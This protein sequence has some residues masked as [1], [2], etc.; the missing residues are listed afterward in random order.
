VFTQQVRGRITTQAEA[1]RIP[2][3]GS[4]RQGLYDHFLL[5]LGTYRSL[6]G[7]P[8]WQ[9]MQ[10]LTE[11]FTWLEIY[12]LL[13]PFIQAFDKPTVTWQDYDAILAIFQYIQGQGRAHKLA[14]VVDRYLSLLINSIVS[15]WQIPSLK[16]M[17]AAVPLFRDRLAALPT[18][19]PELFSSLQKAIDKVW[20]GSFD[21]YLLH[22]GNLNAV[23]QEDELKKTFEKLIGEARTLNDDIG[24][25]ASPIFDVFTMNYT[26]QAAA[27]RKKFEEA[28]NTQL[29]PNTPQNLSEDPDIQ[30]RDINGLFNS[31][32]FYQKN[33][34]RP[35]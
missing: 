30:R 12:P 1:K 27:N 35:F 3:A 11:L 31:N 15:H 23:L 21:S 16:K 22:K 4:Y 25:T 34:F 8:R 26:E 17:L 33:N 6:E 29:K 24:F 14:A 5:N 13:L 2:F 7:N 32:G 20:Y 19:D 18:A 9:E 10:V 28:E